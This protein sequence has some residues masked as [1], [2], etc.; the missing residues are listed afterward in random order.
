VAPFVVIVVFF[1][2]SR[3]FPSCWA[4]IRVDVDGPT[5][6]QQKQ[7]QQQ[8]LELGCSQQKQKQTVRV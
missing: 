6:R 5:W 1:F 8:Q 3:W 2:A 4:S 7:Q